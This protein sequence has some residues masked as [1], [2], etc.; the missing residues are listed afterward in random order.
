MSPIYTYNGKILINNNALAAN[1]NC[2]CDGCGCKLSSGS[3]SYLV[4]TSSSVNMGGLGGFNFCTITPA[5]MNARGIIANQ[6]VLSN[7]GPALEEVAAWLNTL[8]WCASAGCNCCESAFP[9]SASEDNPLWAL[10]WPCTDDGLV[11]ENNLAQ[12]QLEF[13]DIQIGECWTF[14]VI[15]NQDPFD[16]SSPCD[17]DPSPCPHCCTVFSEPFAYIQASCCNNCG[18]LGPLVNFIGTVEVTL[19]DPSSFPFTTS[20]GTANQPCNPAPPN[21]TCFCD[22]NTPYLNGGFTIG[23]TPKGEGYPGIYYMTATARLCRNN[24]CCIGPSGAI[25]LGVEPGTCSYV[26]DTETECE[27]R[28]IPKTL[29]CILHTREVKGSLNGQFAADNVGGSYTPIPGAVSGTDYCPSGVYAELTPPGYGPGNYN[30]NRY[31][32]AYSYYYESRNPPEIPDILPGWQNVGGNYVYSGV[33]APSAD[34]VLTLG[35]AWIVGNSARQYTWTPAGGTT[36]SPN[37]EIS[38]S[39]LD[40]DPFYCRWKSKEYYF[41]WRWVSLANVATCGPA[42]GDA[43]YLAIASA[44]E[45][46]NFYC[47]AGTN[48]CL[49]VANLISSGGRTYFPLPNFQQQL[50]TNQTEQQCGPQWGTWQ[51]GICGEVDCGQQLP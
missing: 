15:N 37:L 48:E 26:F 1:S 28:D 40:G 45:A 18:A 14:R 42:S 21:I 7:I 51:N 49:T 20:T 23:Y 29:C 4:H 19:P 13:P 24:S 9:E 17:T 32:L 31:N 22:A 35:G 16:S 44:A 47:G 12:A 8:G 43:D 27:C 25:E 46:G 39:A 38:E 34:T 2:C 6:F 5:G 36:F 33:G 50:N 30:V 41:E 3:T 11:D 10:E